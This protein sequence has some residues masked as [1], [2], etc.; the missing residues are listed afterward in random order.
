MTK[1]KGKFLQQQQQKTFFETSRKIT[2]AAKK[3]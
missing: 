3:S 1:S 2:A